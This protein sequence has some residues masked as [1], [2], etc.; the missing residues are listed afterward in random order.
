MPHGSRSW[1]A[2]MERSLLERDWWARLRALLPRLVLVWS[3]RSWLERAGGPGSL[4]SGASAPHAA[5]PC[6]DVLSVLCTETHPVQVPVCRKVSPVSSA[7]E[8]RGVRP[9]FGRSY[10]LL[11]S[12]ATCRWS[13]CNGPAAWTVRR[14]FL[15]LGTPRARRRALRGTPTERNVPAACRIV[16]ISHGMRPRFRAE[17][18]CPSLLSAARLCCLPRRRSRRES[19]SSRNASRSSTR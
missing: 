18:R 2:L 19:R 15:I 6:S 12:R 9:W 3:G 5:R 16:S 13:Q 4:S 14:S 1:G 11:A 10:P 8:R 7:P 17:C